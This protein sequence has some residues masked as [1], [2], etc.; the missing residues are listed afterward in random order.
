MKNR[1]ITFIRILCIKLDDWSESLVVP[2][3]LFSDISKASNDK[4]RLKELKQI[5]RELRDLHPYEPSFLKAD[6][7]I[8]RMLIIGR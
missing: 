1:L 8:E 5:V 7:I 2:K 6:A 4:E 3:E